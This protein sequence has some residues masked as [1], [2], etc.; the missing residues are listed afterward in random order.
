MESSSLTHKIAPTNNSP[1]RLVGVHPTTLLCWLQIWHFRIIG[2]KFGGFPAHLS[3]TFTSL[4]WF[5]EM[6]V[7]K[8]VKW[9]KA[10]TLAYPRNPM[11]SRLNQLAQQIQKWSGGRLGPMEDESLISKRVFHCL[12]CLG[13]THTC[14]YIIWVYVQY[15]T[16]ERHCCMLMQFA[17]TPAPFAA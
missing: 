9:I 2:L 5:W 4:E 16:I 10:D 15:R 13:N 12:I 11:S 14:I 1:S 7:A 6:K 3:V 8:V 17:T